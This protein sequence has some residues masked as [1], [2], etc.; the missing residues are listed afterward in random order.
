MIV[1]QQELEVQVQIILYLQ[2]LAFGTVI[3]LLSMQETD[4]HDSPPLI[5]KKKKKMHT[6]AWVV[7]PQKTWRGNITICITCVSVSRHKRIMSGP[8]L[9]IVWCF[10]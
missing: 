1:A 3:A 2:P 10:N 5:K 4:L 6:D 9:V 8:P 7:K